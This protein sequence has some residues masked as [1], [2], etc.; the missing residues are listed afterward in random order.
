MKNI[1]I[2]KKTILESPWKRMTWARELALQ[3][4]TITNW[5]A[6][7][8]N[9]KPETVKKIAELIGKEVKWLNK[10]LTECEFVDPEPE[11]AEPL[12]DINELIRENN[13]LKNQIVDMQAF[14]IRNLVTEVVNRVLDEKIDKILEEKLKGKE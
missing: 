8:T 2:V 11:A 5:L 6:G 7:R 3:R 12:P 4:P 9:P 10:D 14:Y 1:D 13:R